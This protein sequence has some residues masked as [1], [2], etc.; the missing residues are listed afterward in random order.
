VRLVTG[1]IMF[2]Q[3]NV[4]QLFAISGIDEISAFY[5]KSTP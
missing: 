2:S 4:R 5:I 1:V 3:A